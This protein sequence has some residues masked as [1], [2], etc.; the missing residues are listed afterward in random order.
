M[1]TVR[2]RELRVTFRS[3]CYRSVRESLRS[4]LLIIIIRRRRRKRRNTI[5]IIITITKTIIIIIII[6]ALKDAFVTTPHS[7]AN[8]L[9]HVRLSGP[10]AI[11]CRSRAT[12]RALITFNM[13]CYAAVCHSAIKSDR[14]EIA[15]ISALFYWLKPLTD[16]GGWGG[17]GQEYPVERRASQNATY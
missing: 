16:E 1:Q 14:V 17:G 15:S 12:H 9:Q 10:G 4:G 11:V 7:A 5:I 6:I 8:C 2:H 3:R 13:S